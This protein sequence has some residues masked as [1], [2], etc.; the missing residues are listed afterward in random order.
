MTQK[1]SRFYNL[2]LLALLWIPVMFVARLITRL[3]GLDDWGAVLTRLLAESR[4]K[5]GNRWPVLIF[6]LIWAFFFLAASLLFLFS[7]LAGRFYPQG[8]T[9]GL[10]LAASVAYFYKN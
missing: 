2:V 7:I 10:F 1:I 4:D 5:V 9:Y 3:L 6:D 8:F